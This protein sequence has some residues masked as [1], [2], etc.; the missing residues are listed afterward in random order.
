MLGVDIVLMC[1][2][3]GVFVT[4]IRLESQLRRVRRRDESP[5]LQGVRTS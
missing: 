5:L 3:E 2:W 4:C 1:K